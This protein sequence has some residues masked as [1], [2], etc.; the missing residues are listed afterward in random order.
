[1]RSPHVTFS[2]AHAQKEDSIRQIQQW[3]RWYDLELT[4]AEGDSLL[5]L[6]I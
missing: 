5:A 1:L 6:R 4:R 3:A 2:K